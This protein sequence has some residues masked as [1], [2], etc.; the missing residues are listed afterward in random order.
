MTPRLPRKDERAALLDA[1][2][3]E[4]FDCVVIGGGITGAGIARRA[5]LQGMRV[6][7]LEARDFASGTSGASTKLIH[8]GLRY[9]ASGEF[10]LVRKALLER[11]E[12]RRLAPHLAEPRFLYMPADS[13]ARMAYYW[14]G[15]TLYEFLGQ[16]PSTLRHRWA[17]PGEMAL[18]FP[19]LDQRE[20]P[21]AIA[22]CEYFTDDARL[23]LANLRAA[24]GQGARLGHYLPV[25]SLLMEQGR[26]VGVTARCALSGRELRVRARAVVNAA[27]PWADR[28]TRLQPGSGELSLALSRGVHLSVSRKRLPVGSPMFLTTEDGRPLFVIPRD[29]IVYFGTTDTPHAAA[30]DWSPEVTGGDYAYLLANMNRYFPSVSLERRD[31]LCAWAGLRPLIADGRVDSTQALSRKDEV[32]VG[33]NG[34][35]TIAGGKLTGYRQM[36]LAACEAIQAAH[37]E[38]LVPVPEPRLPGAEDTPA[39]EAQVQLVERFGLSADEASRLWHLYGAEAREVLALGAM[40]LRQAEPLFEG[41]VRW[42]ARIEGASSVDDVLRRRARLGV[43]QPMPGT[44]GLN[45]VS[46]LL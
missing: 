18:Q 30:A 7:L 9:L 45:E 27:G 23:V 21:H 33:D 12:I 31:C 26:A 34:L 5:A 32:L 6:A 38:R 8:G 44:A 40:R 36:A 42:A 20:F 14:A 16:V 17:T 39:V 25:N 3:S 37:G 19:E 11:E 29:D 28:M 46:A 41:E 22:Y 4:E 10:S 24:A 35:I 1:M 13:M 15:I 2:A 43:Y